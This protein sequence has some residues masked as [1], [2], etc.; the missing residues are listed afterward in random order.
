MSG[1]LRGHGAAYEARLQLTMRRAEGSGAC[2]LLSAVLRGQ[3]DDDACGAADVAEP[4][5]VPQVLDLAHECRAVVAQ[6]GE[7]VVEVVD[8]ERENADPGSV[9]RGVEVGGGSRRRVELRQFEPAVA[10]RGDH[11][12]DLAPDA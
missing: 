2:R 4:V 8:R 12:G 5:V 9:R 6:P 7:D 10:V 11:E 3:L 1:P